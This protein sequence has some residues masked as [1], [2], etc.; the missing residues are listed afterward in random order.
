M[1]SRHALRPEI[2]FLLG[3][4]VESVPLEEMHRGDDGTYEQIF[5]RFR[6]DAV[7]HLDAIVDVPSLNRDPARAVEFNLLPT[8]RLLELAR[9]H[10]TQHF[11]FSSSVGVLPTIREEPIRADHPVI[12]ESEGP[13]SGF[14]GASKIAAE[15]FALTYGEQFD[16]DVRIVRPSAIYG[17]GM[18][19]PIG[20]KPLIE[21]GVDG[22]PVTTSL[23]D[24][25]R[26]FTHVSD[27]A[28]LVTL[29]LDVPAAADRVFFAG[30]GNPLVT[31]HTLLRT[32]RSLLPPIVVTIRGEPSAGASA[33]S[34][35][36]GVIDMEP[37]HTQLGFRPRYSRLN[38]GLAEYIETY[39]RYRAADELS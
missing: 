3:S 6:P 16:I 4:A 37:A 25:P 26:D 17:F 23:A 15:A 12:T 19:W 32:V 1:V 2:R 14:Y 10:K 27:V 20:V 33:E 30:T 13:G 29:L 7:V 22:I 8:L 39:R 24:P 21:G 11:V 34:R 36:R 18:Q 31:P 5:S 28:Q 9:Q 38:D 35:Y